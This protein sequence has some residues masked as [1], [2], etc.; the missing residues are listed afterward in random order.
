MGG[1]LEAAAP[2][3]RNPLLS[4]TEQAVEA[5]V[6]PDQEQ[7]VARIVTAGMTAA[8]SPQSHSQIFQGL[9]KS[10]DKVHDVALGTVGLMLI[11]SKQSKD[12]MPKTPMLYAGLILML[13]GLDYLEQTMGV[14]IG[15]AELDKATQTFMPVMQEKLGLTPDKLKSMSDNAHKNLQNPAFVQK[16]KQSQMSG[17]K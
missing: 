5:K 8:M 1:M 7:Y 3:M 4:Q 13:H 15:K 6:P 12:T 11:L 14:T 2:A 17:A 10:Q 16:Y 9:D